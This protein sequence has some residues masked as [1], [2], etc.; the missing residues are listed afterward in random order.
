MA[1]AAKKSEQSKKSTTYQKIL[2]A[3]GWKRLMMGRVR[4]PPASKK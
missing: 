4:K 3:E 1:K 2:T